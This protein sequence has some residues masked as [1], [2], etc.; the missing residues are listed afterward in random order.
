MLT[1]Y[2]ETEAS[3]SGIRRAF[4]PLFGQEVNDAKM[5]EILTKYIPSYETV[6]RSLSGRWVSV[7]RLA[8]YE[9]AQRAMDSIGRGES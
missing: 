7:K 6:V 9:T 1:F 3:I 2:L 5:S 4:K 8:E